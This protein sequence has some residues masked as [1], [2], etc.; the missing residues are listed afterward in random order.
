MKKACICIILILSVTAC[1]VTAQKKKKKAKVQPVVQLSEEEIMKQARLEQMTDATQKIV[2]IDSVVTDKN[3]FLEKYVI[4]P[5]N[6]KLCKY[7]EMFKMP[8]RAEAYLHMNGLGNKCY[9]SDK[10]TTGRMSLYTID[11]IGNQWTSPTALSGINDDNGFEQMNFPYIMA[12][13]TTLYFAAQ[14]N[15]SIGGYDIFETRYDSETGRYLKPENIGMPFNSTANDYMYVIDETEGIG[16]F[17]TD[18]NQPEGKIC[19]YTFI[20]PETR[21]MYSTE[22]YTNEQIK[23]FANIESI[24]D[25][26]E[27]GNGRN[28]ALNKLKN[29]RDNRKKQMNH[30]NNISFIINDNITYT[31]I[32][33]FK[34]AENKEKF[35]QLQELKAMA[36]T[37][38]DKTEKMREL[39]AKGNKSDKRQFCD[40]IMKSEK[41]SEKLEIQIKQ[42]EKDI[43]NT[44]NILLNQ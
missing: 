24:A 6:G 5:E 36:K 15:E 27:K 28:N 39:Y 1:P 40:T 11:R 20:V 19:V 18:R 30:D 3:V 23:K 9:F 4:S 32:S 41:E 26:W 21:Q 16:W 42:M 2:F 17:A 12:D 10:D 8:E 13:G 38:D 34:A 14:G 7:N 25:T 37:L 35:K 29:I 44:E 31:N 33:D 43:R 22:N